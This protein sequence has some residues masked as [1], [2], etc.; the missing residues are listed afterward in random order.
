MLNTT[1]VEIL[2]DGDTVNGILVEN[3]Q[4]EAYSIFADAVIVTTGGFGANATMI[5][6]LDGDLEGFGTTNH[7]GA[8]GEGIMMTQAFLTAPLMR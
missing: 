2:K 8:T 1:A 7:P 3:A 4:G 6:D 5:A